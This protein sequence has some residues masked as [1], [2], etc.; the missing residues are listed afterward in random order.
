[1]SLVVGGESGSGVESCS[2]TPRK[3][4]TGEKDAFVQRL[5][6]IVA[7]AVRDVE[8]THGDPDRYAT[9]LAKRIATQLWGLADP[10]QHQCVAAWVKHCRGQL[11]VSQRELAARIGVSQV[12]VARWETGIMAPN[13]EHQTA[14]KQLLT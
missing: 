6:R 7:G 12:T 8:R 14:L 11:G 2:M 13:L 9:S 1:M 10:G 4:A 5:T 3:A